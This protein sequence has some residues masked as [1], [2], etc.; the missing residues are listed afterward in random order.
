[1]YKAVHYALAMYRRTV[2]ATKVYS[3]WVMHATRSERD[4]RLNR[5]IADNEQ[6]LVDERHTLAVRRPG[7]AV[8]YKQSPCPAT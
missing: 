7:A 1:M 6:S 5:A 4:V 2:L 8:I 3:S